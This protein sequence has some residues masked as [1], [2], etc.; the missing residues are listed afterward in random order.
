MDRW[1]IWI[2]KNYLTTPKEIKKRQKGTKNIWAKQ[3][4]KST[5]IY[6]PHYIN[7]ANKQDISRLNKKLKSILLTGV[8]IKIQKHIKVESKGYIYTHTRIPHEH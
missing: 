6:K 7:I 3:K 2:N 1:K 5:F 4:I 8:V